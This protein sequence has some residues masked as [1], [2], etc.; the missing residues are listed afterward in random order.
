M[1]EAWSKQRESYGF[2]E[3]LGKVLDMFPFDEHTQHLRYCWSLPCPIK[4]WPDGEKE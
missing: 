3:T 1:P 2:Q 4:Y